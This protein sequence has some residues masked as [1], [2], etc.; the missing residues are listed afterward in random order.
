M[1][2]PS[3]HFK[4]NFF[5]I[6]PTKNFFSTEYLSVKKLPSG[7]NTFQCDSN[8]LHWNMSV[9]GPLALYLNF[10]I[11]HSIFLFESVLYS[12]SWVLWEYWKNFK[13]RRY[14]K[15]SSC[16]FIA[17]KIHFLLKKGT[18]GKHSSPTEYHSFSFG[19]IP[20]EIPWNIYMKAFPLGL[21]NVCIDV[22]L[23]YFGDCFSL[24]F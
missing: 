8:S 3:I 18:W 15:T 16:V 1:H 11:R 23:Y 6:Y 4:N 14:W 12:C 10:C 13:E 22:F 24:Y 5:L 17:R 20:L 19:A 2:I 9:F 7:L 21:N